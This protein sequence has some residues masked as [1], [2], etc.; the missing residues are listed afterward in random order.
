MAG[1][2]RTA[3]IIPPIPFRIN[4]KNQIRPRAEQKLRVPLCRRPADA[5]D[6]RGI[7]PEL[8]GDLAHAGAPWLTQRGPYGVLFGFG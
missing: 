2:S 4:I 5:L 7:D 6:G 1:R 8:S 3:E